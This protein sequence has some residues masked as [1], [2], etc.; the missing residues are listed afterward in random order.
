M[1]RKE[2]EFTDDSWS[3]YKDSC[4]RYNVFTANLAGKPEMYELVAQ[5][6]G[7]EG[8]LTTYRDNKTTVALS[9]EAGGSDD[10]TLV[11]LV[12]DKN[13][14]NETLERL[15]TAVPRIFNFKPWKDKK[16]K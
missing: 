15:K 9:I 16:K 4:A 1:A 5:Q 7:S 8:F 10:R 6:E 11:A 2:F 14:L 13:R 3:D 12:G